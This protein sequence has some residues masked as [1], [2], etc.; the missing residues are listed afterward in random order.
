MISG[1]GALGSGQ[2]EG[3]LGEEW[4][5]SL[6]W[7]GLRMERRKKIYQKERKKGER[8]KGYQEKRGKRDKEIVGVGIG[9]SKKE[10]RR[11]RHT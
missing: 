8:E 6:P 4:T 1:C 5:D 7:K 11:E 9:D 3:L 2:A 10:V